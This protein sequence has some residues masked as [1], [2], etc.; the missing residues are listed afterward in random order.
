MDP[1]TLAPVLDELT[2]NHMPLLYTELD[3]T[4]V[5]AAEYVAT[6][7]AMCQAAG[8]NLAA[9]PILEVSWRTLFCG[10]IYNEYLI[11]TTVY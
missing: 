10:N 5:E 3:P 1:S 9:T 6:V 8:A 4:T 11:T 2:R 7:N